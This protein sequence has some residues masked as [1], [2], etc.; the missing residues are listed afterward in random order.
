MRFASAYHALLCAVETVFI[1]AAI[2]ALTLDIWR[3]N[4]E[5]R[6]AGHDRD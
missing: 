3:T 4:K 2:V 1:V 6:R 5:F